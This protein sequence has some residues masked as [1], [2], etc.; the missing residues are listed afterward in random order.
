MN[1]AEE[2]E[3]EMRRRASEAVDPRV[4]RLAVIRAA[5][6]DALREAE[7]DATAALISEVES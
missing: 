2:W 3:G 7:A 6:L 4:A 1:S 5:Q